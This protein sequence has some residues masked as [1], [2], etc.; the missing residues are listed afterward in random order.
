MSSSETSSASTDSSEISTSSASSESSEVST[1]SHGTDSSSSI[2]ESLSTFSSTSSAD[3]VKDSKSSLVFQTPVLS[4]ERGSW[5]STLDLSS[6]DRTK[7]QATAR[8]YIDMSGTYAGYVV[9]VY[10]VPVED[11][12]QFTLSIV[13]RRNSAAERSIVDAWNNALLGRVRAA[14][15]EIRA[16]YD[17]AMNPGD[18]PQGNLI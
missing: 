9:K 8:Q 5:T 13:P 7:V 2:T 14:L 11:G 6:I 18:L 4:P 16:E 10:R 1:S 17:A 15:A 3:I 12:A